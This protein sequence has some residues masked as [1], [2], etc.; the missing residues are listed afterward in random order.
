MSKIISLERKK[1][2]TARILKMK[3]RR[4]LTKAGISFILNLYKVDYN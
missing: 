2:T 1:S 4:K 3:A